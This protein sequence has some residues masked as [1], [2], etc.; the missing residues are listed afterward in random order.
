MTEVTIT[1]AERDALYF[2]PPAA[3][4]KEPPEAVQ[5]SLQAKGFITPIQADGRR[6]HT[7]LGDQV[8]RAASF[9]KLTIDG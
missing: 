1:K 2:I 3:G 7:I 5:L 9:L 6:H 4:G 8:K